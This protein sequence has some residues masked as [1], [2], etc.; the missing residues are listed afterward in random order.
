MRVSITESIDLSIVSMVMRE[1]VT[2]E[3]EDCY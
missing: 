3:Y 1:M 2:R